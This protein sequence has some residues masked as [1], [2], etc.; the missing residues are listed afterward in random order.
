MSCSKFE[1]TKE[2]KNGEK[3]PYQYKTSEFAKIIDTLR[4]SLG[5]G[6]QRDKLK[7]QD[8]QMSIP[9]MLKILTG[10]ENEPHTEEDFSKLQISVLRMFKSELD[11]LSGEVRKKK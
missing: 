8:W 2:D 9:E 11:K 3:L 6:H 5:G 4:H 1:R 7:K 10:S